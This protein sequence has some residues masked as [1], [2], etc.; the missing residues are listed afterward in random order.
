MISSKEQQRGA[1]SLFVVIFSALLLTVVTV[2]FMRV[3]MQEQRQATDN[4]L[5]AGFIWHWRFPPMAP[6]RSWR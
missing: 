3:M 2:S 4:D 6:C 1:V 5:D